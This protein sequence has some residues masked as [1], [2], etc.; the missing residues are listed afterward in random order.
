MMDVTS[1]QA[2][3]KIIGE[4]SEDTALLNQMLDEAKA[5][6]Q[7]FS[8]CPDIRSWHLAFG[9]GGVI[10]LLLVRFK[11]PVATDH[12]LWVVVGDLPSAYFST[13]ESNSLKDALDTYCELM[14]DWA[15]AVVYHRGTEDVFPVRAEP[16]VENALELRSRIEFIEKEILPSL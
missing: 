13:D 1:F 5:Y 7:S 4:D 9:I 10:A 15:D 2:E 16:S 6:V 3:S 12:E 14:S 8:W 11:Q